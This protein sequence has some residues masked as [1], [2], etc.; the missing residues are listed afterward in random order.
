[1]FR[2]VRG[3]AVPE[4]CL[5][6]RRSPT[7]DLIETGVLGEILHLQATLGHHTANAMGGPR[8]AALS[9]RW[10]MRERYFLGCMFCFSAEA[11]DPPLHVIARQMLSS[12]R[13]TARHA[14]P[15]RAAVRHMS[16]KDLRFGD[17][18]RALMLK[19]VDQLA[20]AVQVR[21]PAA[22][23]SARG[24]TSSGAGGIWARPRRASPSA[25]AGMGLARGRDAPGGWSLAAVAPGR[26]GRAP[27]A[28]GSGWVWPC[29]S[30]WVC[31]WVWV[32]VWVWVLAW[33]YVEVGA[34]IGT[35]A[36]AG[37]WAWGYCRGKG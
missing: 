5:P 34:C 29:E 30:G 32:L 23:L 31:G 11:L 22:A 35:P 33:A 6:T 24:Q 16:G 37:A 14:A 18:A 7:I 13:S 1:M 21:R 20:N 12:S 26:A 10:G 15:L 25:G 28:L 8:C 19:G 36:G 3:L 17:E 9:V 4:A 27:R 2:H